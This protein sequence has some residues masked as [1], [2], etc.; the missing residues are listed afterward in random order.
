MGV[1]RFGPAVRVRVATE[2]D[3]HAIVSVV[4]AAFVV[5]DFIEGTRTD[6]ANMTELMRKGEF[7]VAEDDSNHIAACVYTEVRGER[8]YLG[9]LSV[10]P[11]RQGTGLGRVMVEAAENHCR[12]R[13]CCWID[14]RVLSPRRE[15]LP[16]YA[17][18]GYTQLRTEDFQPPRPLRVPIECYG[19]ILSK[20]L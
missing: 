8:G 1:A 3:I 16:F 9:M 15:L 12:N 17:K 20:A 5:E 7:L 18:F 6:V 2:R 11:P 14:L 19:I 4:N 10:D 13:G